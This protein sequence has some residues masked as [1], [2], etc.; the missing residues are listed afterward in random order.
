MWLLISSRA[1][2]IC[3]IL[4]MCLLR[5]RTPICESRAERDL[6][7]GPGGRSAPR[8]APSSPDDDDALDPEASSEMVSRDV[9][10]SG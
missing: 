9:L 8:I 4:T 1:M 6:A 10:K 3:S 2:H 7:D 5:T